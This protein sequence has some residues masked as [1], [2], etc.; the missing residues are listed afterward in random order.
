VLSVEIHNQQSTLTVD[1][2]RLR[3]AVLAVLG[4]GQVAAGNVSVAVVDDATIRELNREYLN[5]DYATDVLS[6]VLEQSEGELEGEVVVSADKARTTAAQ[7]G[8]RAE[9]ELLLYVIHGALHLIG[10]DDQT[11]EARAAMRSREA[12]HLARF[13]LQPRYEE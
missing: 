5:H 6:F 7:F 9:D 11:P 10:H 13:G 12:H 8:W 3:A 2:N 1:E 4:D